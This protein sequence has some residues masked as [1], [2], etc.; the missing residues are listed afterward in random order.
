MLT[1]EQASLARQVV[2]HPV[3][4]TWPVFLALSYFPLSI[5]PPLASFSIPR[6]SSFLP[7]RVWLAPLLPAWLRTLPGKHPV[8][9]NLA[10]FRF[11]PRE[12]ACTLEAVWRWANVFFVSFFHEKKKTKT[13][14]CFYV[15]WNFRQDASSQRQTQDVSAG[16]IAT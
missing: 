16:F 5:S 6:S 4:S 3:S 15:L 13:F 9:R 11:S 12:H 2:C 1:T 10:F 14:A 8:F 7:P